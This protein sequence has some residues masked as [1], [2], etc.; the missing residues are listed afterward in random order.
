M[1]L[2]N[3]AAFATYM[4]RPKEL[5][6]EAGTVY[7]KQL[8]VAEQD[9]LRKQ[10][11]KLDTQQDDVAATATMAEVLASLLT[12]ES[13]ASIFVTDEDK[14]ALREG[15]TLDFIREFFDVFWGSFSFT[16][17][18]L[19]AAQEQFRDKPATEAKV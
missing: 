2:T 4:S 14:E 10:W 9:I 3:A 17:K 6:L 16:E 13:G 15:L 12:D 19:A 8:R 1:K 11:E 7:I 18:E 5:K